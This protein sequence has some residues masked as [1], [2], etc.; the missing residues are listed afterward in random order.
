[1]VNISVLLSEIFDDKTFSC[2]LLRMP[3][4]IKNS[5]IT[6]VYKIPRYH[7]AIYDNFCLPY[8]EILLIYTICGN[9]IIKM[10]RIKNE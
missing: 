10:K 1:M 2:L 8:T 7:I 9:E 3:C 5:I 4:Q 6:K